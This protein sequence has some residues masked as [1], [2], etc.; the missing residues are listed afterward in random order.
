M[1]WMVVRC[2]LTAAPPTSV[3]FHPGPAEL[4]PL[5]VV[6]QEVDGAVQADNEVGER[7]EVSHKR[8]V[9]ITA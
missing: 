1:V 9:S 2:G 5:A 7:D 8:G 3:G 4:L 6:D